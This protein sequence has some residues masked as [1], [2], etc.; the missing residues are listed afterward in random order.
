M[1]TKQKEKGKKEL[2]KEAKKEIKKMEERN[3]SKESTII[4]KGR[5]FMQ[6][7]DMV[8]SSLPKYYSTQNGTKEE[9]SSHSQMRWKEEEEKRLKKMQQIIEKNGETISFAITFNCSPEI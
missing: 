3:N 1:K 5:W 2:A 8:I 4:N 9:S 6:L 7:T